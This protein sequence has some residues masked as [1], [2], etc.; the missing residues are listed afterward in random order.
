MNI[1]TQ[2]LSVVTPE[3]K[4]LLNDVNTRLPYGKITAIIGRN[5]AG[6][7]TLLRAIAGLIS[8]EGAVNYG[9]TSFSSLSVRE[10]ALLRAVLPQQVPSGVHFAVTELLAMGIYASAAQM[11]ISDQER[12]L[13]RVA[14]DFKLQDL[15]NRRFSSL[16]GGEQQRVLLARAVVQLRSSGSAHG[17]L[18]L[19]EPLN[20]LDIVQQ[21]AFFERLHLLKKQGLTVVAVLHDINHVA[22]VADHIVCLHQGEVLAQ[23]TPGQVLVDR[24]F[25]EA[26]AGLNP[27]RWKEQK[28]TGPHSNEERTIQKIAL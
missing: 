18:F 13:E 7:S 27:L 17:V 8:H 2:R 1:V 25:H 16:S 10:Q 26:F 11:S 21:A 20:H 9:E 3:G 22:R 4:R 24:L 5:G 15:L 6:K 14:L 23:G 19:D 12:L 28:L